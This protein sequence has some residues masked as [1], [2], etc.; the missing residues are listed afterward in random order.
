LQC[1]STDGCEWSEVAT[2]YKGRNASG[3]KRNLPVY[4]D[5]APRRVAGELSGFNS[6]AST[7]VVPSDTC[8][9][10]FQN[11]NQEGAALTLEPGRYE[12]RDYGFEDMATS[13]SIESSASPNFE[14]PAEVAR[15]YWD[16]RQTGKQWPVRSGQDQ[17]KLGRFNDDAS[18]VWVAPGH[19]LTLYRDANFRGTAKTYRAGKHE[20]SGFN[21]Q[22]SSLRIR[23][24]Q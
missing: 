1:Y 18:S 16:R 15:L 8:L 20:L 9:T 19:C 11:K 3:D 13:W 14:C 6:V 21:D 4:R 24:C 5:Q 2:L 22:A 10:L 12:L 23:E 7:A 17:T